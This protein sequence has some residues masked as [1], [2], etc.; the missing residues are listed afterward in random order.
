M[1]HL[2][3]LLIAMII[4]Q[5]SFSTAHS[6]FI[7]STELNINPHK[8]THVFVVGRGDELGELLQK[9]AISKALYTKQVF[10]QDQIL[11]IGVEEYNR[12][13]QLA[14]IKRKGFSNIEFVPASLNQDRLFS[15]L[16]LFQN[17]ASL[18][19][20]THSAVK[21]G[22]R[23]DSIEDRLEPSDDWTRIKKSLTPDAFIFLNG[24]NTGFILAPAVSKQLG[25]PTFGSMTAT[26]IDRKA[27]DG[28]FYEVEA[29]L[30]IG[31]R[32]ACD[33]EPCYRMSPDNAPYSGHWGKFNGGGLGFFKM[34]CHLADQEQCLK[35]LSLT[36]ATHIGVT[37]LGSP[38][39]FAEAKNNYQNVV[40]ERLC[41]SYGSEKT[42][43][44]CSRQ[45]LNLN[46]NYNPFL[47]SPLQCSMTNCD[48]E[49][50]CRAFDDKCDL[51]NP[52]TRSS[53]LINEYQMY[54]TA[55]DLLFKDPAKN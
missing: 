11:L 23:L 7:G 3:R 43:N 13:E 46:K 48:F 9:A 44:E 5:A 28:K 16:E 20:F 52:Y 37:S 36:L 54:M 12:D 41:P 10:P 15:K 4:V 17:I 26:N 24:C 19:F 29:I 53:T 49:L 50:T 14:A 21:F 22:M 34:F 25:V 6:Y 47:G 2:I 38:K 1:K 35:T 42:K 30:P 45:I 40:L 8:R 55:F 31:V 32:F 27:S 39:N 33:R 51:I 18:H